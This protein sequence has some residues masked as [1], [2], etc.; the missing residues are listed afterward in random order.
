MAEEGHARETDLGREET[1]VRTSVVGIVANV[2]LAA[3]KAAV[4]VATSSVAVTMDA[5]NN[6][7]DALS[8]VITIVGTRLAGRAPDR[9]HP[10]GYGRV[11]YLSS[12][13]IS[14]IV[15]YAGITSLSESV[16]KVFRPVTP[17]YSATSLAIIA[18]AVV[19]KVLLGRYV[20][21]TGRRVNCDSLVASGADA[22]FDAVLSGATLAAALIFLATG[23]SVEA[24][25]GAVIS[26]VIVKSGIEM[27]GDTLSQ[28]LGERA[29][30]ELSREVRRLVEEDPEAHGAYDLVMHAYG[31]E[32]M[33]A[34]VHT[35]VPDTMRAGDIDEMTRRIQERV[36]RETDGRV[37]LAAVGIYSLNTHDDAAAAVRERVTRLVMAHE[38]VLQMHGFH[39]SGA[40][41][42]GERSLRF[43]VVLDFAL[44]DREGTYQAIVDDV[45]REFPDYRLQ[46]TLDV[47]ASD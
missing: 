21:A 15:I 23:V 46:V 6:L 18:V 25:V 4:G 22:T 47:D 14:V 1:I 27:L 43:D 5:V 16:S 7:S 33:V 13:A 3:F 38:G 41:G 39:V 2:L 19:V 28:I 31:P 20:G 37:I 9:R 40:D 12:T 35:E 29:N 17:E 42:R 44:E 24:W 45:R 11:E 30:A 34:S 8:S 26:V 36:Y 32:R 10:F